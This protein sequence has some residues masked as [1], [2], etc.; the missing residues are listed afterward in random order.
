[1][2]GY[3]KQQVV[4]TCLSAKV[5]AVQQNDTTD[6]FWYL[7][8]YCCMLRRLV[9][10]KVAILFLKLQLLFRDETAV[11]IDHFVH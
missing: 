8:V 5:L 11:G 2:L 9:N 1:M 7:L 10:A 3:K 4:V 6:C